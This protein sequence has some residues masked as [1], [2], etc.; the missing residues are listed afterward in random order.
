MFH[1]FSQNNIHAYILYHLILLNVSILF[2]Y[3]IRSEYIMYIY[4]FPLNSCRYQ[5]T[6]YILNKIKILYVYIY[7]ILKEVML[8]FRERDIQSS[9]S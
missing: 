7:K 5:N 9:M 4:T 1:L 3:Y 6:T 8:T 2:T